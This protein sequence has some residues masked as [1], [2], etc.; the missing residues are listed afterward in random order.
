MSAAARIQLNNEREMVIE[1]YRAKKAK[2][3][4]DSGIA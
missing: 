4:A 1:A 3:M 2:R